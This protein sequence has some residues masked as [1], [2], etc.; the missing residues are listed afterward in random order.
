MANKRG[1]A[2]FPPRLDPR[3]Q[4]HYWDT[5]QPYDWQA[6]VLDEIS[7]PRSRVAVSS[8]N[9]AGKTNIIIPLMGLSIMTTFP[10]ATVWSTAGAEPQIKDQLWKYL[11]TKLEP[12]VKRDGSG[13][14]LTPSDMTILAPRIKIGD[15]FYRSRWTMRVPKDSKTMEGLHGAWHHGVWT[16]IAIILD[17]AKSLEHDRFKSAWRI[18]PDFFLAI[19]TPPEEESGAFF[20][21]LPELFGKDGA[22]RKGRSK[23]GLWTAQFKITWNECPHL[24][25]PEKMA[26]KEALIAK[27]GADSSYIKSSLFGEVGRESDPNRVFLS[28]DLDRIRELMKGKSEWMHGEMR[29][30]LDFSG[31][32]DEQVIGIA[33]GN[34]VVLWEAFKE[35]DTSELAVMFVERLTKYNVSPYNCTA[36]NGGLGLAVI[37]A[38]ENLGY[39]GVYRYMSNQDPM[40]DKEYADRISEDHY[41]LK[42]KLHKYPIIL[43]DDS[44]L[45]RQ[46]SQRKWFNND[47]NKIKLELKKV[48]RSRTGESPDRLDTLVQLFSDW[49]MPVDK[50]KK[51]K[52]EEAADWRTVKDTGGQRSGVL[53][54]MRPFRQKGMM[55]QVVGGRMAGR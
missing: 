4:A 18:D 2:I 22:K 20:D 26:L 28:R 43:P 45:F 40:N 19:S 42:E 16:P 33:D 44:L 23:D 46:M 3:S 49:E 37:D 30:A 21:Y 31:G 35:L 7:K 54:W 47:H 41:M 6:D 13:W 55:E 38:I 12:F 51:K 39:R 5:P 8:C 24:H 25:T 9:E 14:V 11:E 53:G 17:E 52:E 36:D 10:G 34:K 50:I 15:H 32:G 48:H 29:A 1:I 27:F